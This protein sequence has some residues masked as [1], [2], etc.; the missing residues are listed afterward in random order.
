MTKEYKPQKLTLKL[1]KRKG[2]EAY[3]ARKLTAQHPNKDKRACVYTEGNYHCVIGA[4][5]SNSA[6]KRV[7]ELNHRKNFLALLTAK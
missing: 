2:L 6:L 4:A 5:L 7:G 3:K 1:V